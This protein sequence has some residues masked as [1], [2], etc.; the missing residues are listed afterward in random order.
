[1]ATRRPADRTSVSSAMRAVRF[2]AD[3]F[4]FFGGSSAAAGS[5]AASGLSCAMR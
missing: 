5:G 2:A 4:F 3:F 1:M